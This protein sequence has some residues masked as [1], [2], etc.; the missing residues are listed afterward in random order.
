MLKILRSLISRVITYLRMIHYKFNVNN[1]GKH[2]V[3]E[4]H[5]QISGGNNIIIN[6]NVYIA[7]NSWLAAVSQTGYN[8]LLTID[9]ECSIGNSNHI[10]CTKSITLEKGVLTARG[11]YISD[12]THCY[13][14]CGQYIKEQPIKQLSPVIIGE[15][16]WI[17]EN[18]CVIGA[19]IGKHCVI[20]ALSLVNKDI[21]DY[22]VAVGTPAQI[23]KRYDFERKEWRKT[24]K[25]GNFLI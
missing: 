1:I 5:T 23:I 17:G 14:D 9:N 21:P 25:E 4:P 7:E 11:V 19:K 18:S 6:D 12:N 15:G 22:C 13:D 20:G 2:S 8:P 3:I 10:Y 24:D 16:S